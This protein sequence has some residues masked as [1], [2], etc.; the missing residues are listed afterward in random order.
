[1]VCW[2]WALRKEPLRHRQDR[3]I[4]RI[5]LLVQIRRQAPA[6]IR[7][8]AI[9][10]ALGQFRCRLARV[11]QASRPRQG[12]GDRAARAGQARSRLTCNEQGAGCSGRLP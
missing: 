5:H 8:L 6:I 7:L 2:Q 10:G 9:L 11:I 1:M 4:I 12:Q 3:A